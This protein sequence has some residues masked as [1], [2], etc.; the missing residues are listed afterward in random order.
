MSHWYDDVAKQLARGTNPE[1]MV[2][3]S[4]VRAG[5]DLMRIAFRKGKASILKTS[6]DRAATLD[7]SQC[8]ARRIGQ[9]LVFEFSTAVQFEGKK[10][11][12]E[13]TITQVMNRNGHTTSRTSIFRGDD[14]LLRTDAVGTSRTRSMDAQIRV[15][16]GKAF[17]GA[18]EAEFTTE[19]GKVFRAIVDGRHILP[20]PI[21]TL[22]PLDSLRFEDGNP[23]P[24]VNI[25]PG[26]KEALEAIL[27][28]AKTA[29]ESC[30]KTLSKNSSIL[31][32]Q[33]GHGS[34]PQTSGE[35][36]ACVG[37]CAAGGVACGIGV[38]LG[39][40]G[41][42]IGYPFCVAAG[43]AGCALAE[44]GCMKACHVIGGPCCPVACGDVACCDHAET[45]LDPRI[46]LC[47]AKGL[48]P[49]ANL[50]CC[51]PTD[52]CIKANGTCCPKGQVMCKDILCCEPGEVCKEGSICCPVDQVTCKGVCCE[53]GEVCKKGVCC[54]EEQVVCEG[55]C[56]NPGEVC[57]S[58]K[59]CAK[60]SVC[61]NVCCNELQNCA[62]PAKNLCC[63]FAVEICGGICCE[64]GE[65]CIDGKCCPSGRT[66]GTKVCCGEH[67]RC[68]DPKKGTCEKCP[69][70]LV[71]CMEE[72]GSPG[73]CCAPHVGCCQGKC[74]K[75]GQ[76]CC[77]PPGA[78]LGLDCH[79]PEECLA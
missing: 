30:V 52:Q 71:G 66:C 70:D 11:K 51:E 21:Q 17:E 54:P 8:Q 43:A 10:L 34:T 12:L 74:C 59:C 69:G 38:G 78:S 3:T 32:A 58:G 63:S 65:R 47:C 13:K 45:C 14:L 67:E 27:K 50:S 61:G 18:R 79:F 37:G 64:I 25:Q 46:G 20:F 68:V 2:L 48:D 1:R 72:T 7:S 76:I 62:D 39:C 6:V 40:A 28:N 53:S 49:C 24:S 73:I 26:T 57:N 4:S 36:I 15:T 33:S 41:T 56:C 77:A 19:D 5:L 75:P 42:L 29:S 22:T 44:I 55:V 60:E 16:F 9:R 35:C 31:N 23:A